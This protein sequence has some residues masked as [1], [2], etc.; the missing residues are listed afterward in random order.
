LREAFRGSGGEELAV[1]HDGEAVGEGFCEGALV[2]DHD[3]GHAELRL[4]FAEKG[5]DGFAGGGIEIAGGLVGEKN[6]RAIDESAGDGDAL[7]FAAGKFRGAMAEA[8]REAN[9]FEGFTDAGGAL[10]AIDFS[11]A[12]REFD[13]FL[14]GHAREKVEGLKD[15]ADGVAAVAGEI[16]GGKRGDVPAVGEDGA[17]GGAVEAGDEIEERGFAGAGGAEE[18]E[19]FVVGDGEGE[20][21][22][23]ADGSFA[24]GVVA[25]DAV[26]L[27]GGIGG[28]HRDG[29][30][31]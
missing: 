3:D 14:E 19:E 5:E 25:G 21:V 10:G 27:D 9:A 30:R 13:V 11:E 15:H 16:E 31:S 20:F 22:D 12:K 2:G 4:E 29:V 26:E 28:G 17:G 18:G 24:H 23:G 8:M 6:L 7:L 1:A